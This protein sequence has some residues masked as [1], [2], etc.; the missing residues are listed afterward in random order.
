[1]L[2][3]ISIM[4]IHLIIHTNSCT[5]SEVSMPS[6]TTLMMPW[7]TLGDKSLIVEVV[8][9]HGMMDE[10]DHLHKEIQEC[11]EK[12]YCAGNNNISAY[13]VLSRL[14]CWARYSRRKRSPM[15]CR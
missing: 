8:W 4:A 14:T 12:L 5:T 3:L 9:F 6:V 11:E 10:I 2:P 1:M 15:D 7:S 13:A